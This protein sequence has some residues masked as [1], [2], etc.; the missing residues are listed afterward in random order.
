MCAVAGHH[1]VLCFARAA[2]VCVCVFVCV[3]V[4]MCVCVCHASTHNNG[5]C[6]TQACKR[7]HTHAHTHTHTHTNT[8]TP[9]RDSGS[10]GAAEITPFRASASHTCTMSNLDPKNPWLWSERASEKAKSQ[11]GRGEGGRQDKCDRTSATKCA[12]AESV[13]CV[14]RA[15]PRACRGR[16][17]R[18]ACW[19]A[20]ATPT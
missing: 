4:C 12:Q 7:A 9:E 10:S 6:H 13:H 15:R 16:A 8:H 3:C 11:S 14:R 2:I 1:Q 19:R 18:D 20:R 17:P 5:T